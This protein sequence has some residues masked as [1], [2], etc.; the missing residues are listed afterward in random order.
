MN[1]RDH[2]LV[3]LAEEAGEIVQAAAKALRFGLDAKSPTTGIE[4]GEALR[5]EIL[6][7]YAVVEMLEEDEAVS[8]R[9]FLDA[10]AHMRR[11]KEKVR[12]HL[13]VSRARKRLS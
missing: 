3:I 8:A 7:L 4:N 1:Q 9:N 10:D 12:H 2:L 5:R 6:D 11:K 13:E